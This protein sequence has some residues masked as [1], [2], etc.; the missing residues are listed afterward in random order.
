MSLTARLVGVECEYINLQ[1]VMEVLVVRPIGATA[2]VLDALFYRGLANG[3]LRD[4]G[5]LSK[6]KLTGY[7]TSSFEVKANLATTQPSMLGQ[8]SSWMVRNVGIAIM[9][10]LYHRSEVKRL[11]VVQLGTDH[12][13]V[14]DRDGIGFQPCHFSVLCPLTNLWYGCECET[15]TFSMSG[16]REE[17]YWN[18]MMPKLRMR[19]RFLELQRC[20]RDTW[21]PKSNLGRVQVPEAGGCGCIACNFYEPFR[22]DERSLAYIKRCLRW[23]CV[24]RFEDSESVLR[25][26]GAPCWMLSDKAH[27]RDLLRFTDCLHF[28]RRAEYHCHLKGEL[29]V[30][31]TIPAWESYCAEEEKAAGAGEGD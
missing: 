4:C 14:V 10:Q 28:K 5:F 24:E 31:D 15:D 12:V 7:S 26:L 8:K 20:A 13:Q 6:V 2:L 16:N 27:V 3:L 9:K 29:A 17:Y 25:R 30:R 21:E 11:I 22:T 23:I 1:V 18:V 19:R